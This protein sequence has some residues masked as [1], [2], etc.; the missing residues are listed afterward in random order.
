MKAELIKLCKKQHLPTSGSKEN[1]LEYISNF[2][3]NKPVE[4]TK[5][6]RVK[7]NFEPALE[8]VIDAN[9]SNSEIHRAFFVETI[10]GTF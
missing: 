3:E 1:L 6:S 8:K 4:K 7:S 10:G 5:V 9:Y 2:I